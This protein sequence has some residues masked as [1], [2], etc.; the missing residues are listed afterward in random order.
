MGC[1]GN[2]LRVSKSSSG[3]Q[4]GPLKARVSDYVLL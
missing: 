4:W 1:E 3:Y 2:G